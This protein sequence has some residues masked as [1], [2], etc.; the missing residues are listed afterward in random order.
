MKDRIVLIGVTAKSFEEYIP[1]PYSA[2]QGFYEEIP[3]VIVQAQMVSQLLS[4]V[5]DGRPVL[6]VWPFLGEVV[7]VWGWS[8]VGGILVWRCRS[9]LR[10]VLAGGAALNVLYFLCFSLFAQGSWVPLVPSVLALVFTGGSVV[11]YTRS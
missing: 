8:V 2:G 7:W 11:A 10:L 1:I 4:A 9:L 5:L 6:S 3:G